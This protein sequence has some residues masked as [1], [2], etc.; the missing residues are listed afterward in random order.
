[1]INV[2]HINSNFL[3][4]KL[5]ENLIDQ[6]ESDKVH[7]KI[8]MPMKREKKEEIIYESKH[9]VYNPVSFVDKD[10]YIFSLKQYKIMKQLKAN[11]DPK[12][13]NL[14]HAHTLFTDGNVAY[15]LF[16]E[17]QI[18]YV[19]TVRGY[20]DINSFFKKRPNLRNKGRAILKNASRIVFLSASNRKE[21]LD[22]FIK[23]P[24]DKKDILDKSIINPNGIDD[25][26]FENANKPKSEIDQK[27]IK[28]IYAGKIMKLKNIMGTVNAIR[29]LNRNP[30][31]HASL[32][33][34]GKK[35]ESDYVDIVMNVKDIDITIIEPKPREKLIDIYRENDI[36]IMPS[37]SETFGLVYPEAMSQGLP[38]IYTKG[39][40]FDGQFPDGEVGYPVVATDPKDISEKIKTAVAHY[41]VLSENALKNFMKFNWMDISKKYIK[42]YNEIIDK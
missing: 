24:E 2:L 26:W 18:P 1:M 41:N 38:V 7:N 8:F 19:V 36:F 23:K 15:R 16:K 28:L 17:Y 11:L 10:K 29:E 3:T 6:L 14:T 13:F 37:F 33:I 42:M 34:V 9:A 40:G 22:G 4:S 39:Q 12:Q 35:F 5:H 27:D 31:Y 20:T 25:F 21:L 30:E 32:T